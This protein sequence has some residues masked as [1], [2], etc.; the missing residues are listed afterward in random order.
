MTHAFVSYAREDEAIV[1]RLCGDLRAH[2][3]KVWL[4]RERIQPGELW[5][6]AIT[7]AIDQG[8]YFIACLS[9]QY[10][11]K[12][13]FLKDELGLGIR[14]FKDRHQ[15]IPVRIED[16]EIPGD[17]VA[18]VDLSTLHWVDV[19]RDWNRGIV[20]IANAIGSRF[21]DF[22]VTPSWVHREGERSRPMVNF[23]LSSAFGSSKIFEP[24]E[25][26]QNSLW[27][28]SALWKVTVKWVS[29]A[30]LDCKRVGII[31][32]TSLSRDE[33]VL[34]AYHRTRNDGIEEWQAN[35][36]WQ[37]TGS[38]SGSLVTRCLVL[39]W[40]QDGLGHTFYD[41]NDGKGYVVRWEPNVSRYA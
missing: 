5:E 17:V 20:Q 30:N 6:D 4:D 28:H 19:F 40:Y 16:C 18:N 26:Y 15:F 33:T 29:G 3:V 11:A 1:D 8:D 21:D 24:P 31:R 38:A 13:G 27:A 2:G 37:T 12:S 39:A 35:E 41:D 32:R 34:A 14:R 10:L 7:N 25:E 9:K 36:L 22:K 23:D